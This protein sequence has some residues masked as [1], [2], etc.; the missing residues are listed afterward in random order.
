MMILFLK[1]SYY[2]GSQGSPQ[3]RTIFLFIVMMTILFAVFEAIEYLLY[4]LNKLSLEKFAE[5]ESFEFQRG[6]F[7]ILG[8]SEGH[9]LKGSYRGWKITV[10]HSSGLFFT[11]FPLVFYSSIVVSGRSR[12]NARAS[13]RNRSRWDIRH[14]PYKMGD[15]K[16][17]R[18]IIVNSSPRNF[19]RSILRNEKIRAAIRALVFPK[20]IRSSELVIT[21]AG[22][23][24]FHGDPIFKASKLEFWL[25]HLCEIAEGVE[26]S[27]KEGMEA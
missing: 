14:T 8:I 19:A 9:L 17:E 22:N 11:Q 25:D 20:L 21:R 1:N 18:R 7:H 15:K 5:R 13:F 10:H 6:R 16:F 2:F 12:T 23:F 27:I 4:L 24:R 26:T 3:I